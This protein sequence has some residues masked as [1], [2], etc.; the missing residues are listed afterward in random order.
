M[1]DQ[2]P[3]ELA[4][5]VA[6]LWCCCGDQ[7]IGM[8]P[9]FVDQQVRGRSCLPEGNVDAGCVAEKEIPRSGR[10]Q[11]WGETIERSEDRRDLRMV[12]ANV[13][14]VE[15]SGAMHGAIPCW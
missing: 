7:V 15:E 11:G 14:G 2:K 10:E 5:E 1:S 3:V 13:P 4:E 6:R 12:E 8:R 9:P